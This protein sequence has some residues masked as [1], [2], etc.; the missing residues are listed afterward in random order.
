MAKPGVCLAIRARKTDLEPCDQHCDREPDRPPFLSTAANGASDH[1]GASSTSPAGIYP[2][3][4][5]S[6]RA[7]GYVRHDNCGQ[8]E[9]IPYQP[10]AA[11]A[12]DGLAINSRTGHEELS[13]E[14][15]VDPIQ[16]DFG[17]VKAEPSP[18][19]GEPRLVYRLFCTEP[20]SVPMHVRPSR[21]KIGQA[22]VLRRGD[23]FRQSLPI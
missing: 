8:R 1:P 16:G 6:G 3:K 23:D 7:L 12:A 17:V 19:E 5:R 4:Q 20:H 22:P 15:A 9:A 21:T 14:P 2:I 11:E 18:R 13:Y 10:P